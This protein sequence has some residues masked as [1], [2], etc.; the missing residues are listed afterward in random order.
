MKFE[1]ISNFKVT[2]DWAH[3]LSGI[4]IRLLNQYYDNINSKRAKVVVLI[5]T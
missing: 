1:V 3:F 4:Y 2:V 5:D